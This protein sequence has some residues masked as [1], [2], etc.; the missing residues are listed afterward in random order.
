MGPAY[1][2]GD[3]HAEGSTG[4]ARGDVAGGYAAGLLGALLL[5]SAGAA[6]GLVD[7]DVLVAVVGGATIG[8]LI[9]SILG[10]TLERRGVVNNDVLNFVNTATAAYVAIR[11]AEVL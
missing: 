3:E 7:W 6:L 9:E 5:A 11:L 8:A 4:H 1:L 2:P 10:A